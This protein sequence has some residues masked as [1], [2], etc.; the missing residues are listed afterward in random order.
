[1]S[2]WLSLAAS[3]P[4]RG[5]KKRPHISAGR[6]T[7]RE[8]GPG[9]AVSG[10]RNP[11]LLLP[12]LHCLG[13]YAL[14]PSVNQCEATRA[15]RGSPCRLAKVLLSLA[16]TC[17]PAC[18]GQTGKSVPPRHMPKFKIIHAGWTCK[19]PQKAATQRA[20]TRTHFAS[21]SCFLLVSNV[22]LERLHRGQLI[23]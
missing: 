8:M 12:K 1:M 3:G 4:C 20:T 13:P 22:P 15:A 10:W 6:L 7:R 5:R 2:L 11:R 14:I 17:L 9:D 19:H 23:N 16:R 21:L 18:L